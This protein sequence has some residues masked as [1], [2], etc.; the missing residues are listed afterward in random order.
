M[1]LTGFGSSDNPVV[2]SSYRQQI[3]IWSDAIS[4]P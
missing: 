3:K 1:N 4:V 2:G